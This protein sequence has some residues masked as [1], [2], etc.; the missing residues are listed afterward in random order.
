MGPPKGRSLSRVTD[1]EHP[2]EER[3][4]SCRPC[5]MKARKGEAMERAA[6]RRLTPCKFEGCARRIYVRGWCAHHYQN[7]L[8]RGDPR[9]VSRTL[10]PEYRAAIQRSR[11]LPKTPR[12]RECKRG[13]AMDD[14]NTYVHPNRSIRECVA[15]RRERNKALGKKYR[16]VIVKP[17]VRRYVMERDAWTCAY[18][19][20]PATTIDHVAPKAVRRR[21]GIDDNDPAFLVAACFDH[22]IAKM[23]RKLYP[24]GFDASRLPGDGWRMWDGSAESLRE[25]VR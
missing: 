11:A 5:R 10:T 24:R 1:C 19:G 4:Q 2:H 14:A 7:W 12:L 23:T 22:N 13:H 16:P 20:C 6:A 15:C 18:G 17:D 9:P 25:V 21:F 3:A 8:L